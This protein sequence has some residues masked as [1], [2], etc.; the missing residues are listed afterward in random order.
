MH[1][2]RAGLATSCSPVLAA[3]S[4]QIERHEK[5]VIPSYS[6]SLRLLFYS[7]RYYVF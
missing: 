4:G 3:L 7:S 6:Y 5:Q 2:L 1:A